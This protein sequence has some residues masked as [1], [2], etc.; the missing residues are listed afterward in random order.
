MANSP[1]ASLPVMP[2]LLMASHQHHSK[3]NNGAIN[4]NNDISLTACQQ[5]Q[6][7]RQHQQ[8]QQ[9][10]QFYGNGNAGCLTSEIG[11]DLEP[12]LTSDS[13]KRREAFEKAYRVGP[14]IG[15]GGF[16]KVFA[17]ERL[18]D[19]LPVAIKHINKSKISSWCSVSPPPLFGQL[20]GAQGVKQQTTAQRL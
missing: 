15:K 2:A 10:Q 3:H 9:Q 8:Q 13:P 11:P 18:K 7:Q 1:P 19:R 5:Q 6:Q 20:P 17:G 16:G 14:V 4:N 12:I